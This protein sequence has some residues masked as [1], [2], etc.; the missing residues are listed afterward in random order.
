MDET[1]GIV[2]VKQLAKVY[3]MGEVNVAAL[4]SVTFTIHDGEYVAIMGPSGS[5]KSTL[6]NLLGCL[7]TPSS[8]SYFLAGQ[9]VS[10]MTDN[11]LSEV[12]RDRIGFVFQSF[13]LISQLSVLENIELPLI[14]ADVSPAERQERAERLAQVV[15]LGHRAGHRPTEL[16]G[17]EMQRVAIARALSN[18]PVMILADEPTGNLDTHTGK[19]IM[20]L[21]HEVWERGATLLT[22]THDEKVAEHAPRQIRLTDGAVIED[23]G[24]KQ[25]S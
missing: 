16:S 24:V 15:G 6:L 7:D 13:N 4:K 14:Y 11:A 17:G 9:D 22:V 12:R 1:P 19:E 2:A 25:A 5:G 23:T 21:L 3:R 10:R 8:G 20:A 18:D